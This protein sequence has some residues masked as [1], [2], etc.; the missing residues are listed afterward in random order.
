M[1]Y[2]PKTDAAL[3]LSMPHIIFYKP[4]NSINT[5]RDPA[6]ISGDGRAV[7]DAD[8]NRESGNDENAR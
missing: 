7:S 8:G 2:G 5:N 1:R 6:D 3:N 4:L